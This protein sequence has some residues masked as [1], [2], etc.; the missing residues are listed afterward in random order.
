M[1]D[2]SPSAL[3]QVT[4]QL[5]AVKLDVRELTTVVSEFKITME[6]TL[7][8]IEF[9][10]TKTNGRVTSLEEDRTR[11]LTQEASRKEYEAK[12]ETFIAQYKAP[13]ITAVAVLIITF[14]FNHYF[15]V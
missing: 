13:V 4:N 5:T 1:S 6:K 7:E 2:I 8:R 15:P 11:R 3:E 12:E 14:I 9:Q 10:T